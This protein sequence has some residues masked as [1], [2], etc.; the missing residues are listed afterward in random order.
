MTIPIRIQ[1]AKNF[2]WM[3]RCERGFSILANRI[4]LHGPNGRI[5]RADN[6]SGSNT[7]TAEARCNR[8]YAYTHSARGSKGGRRR[9][10]Q[11]RINPPP[12]LSYRPVMTLS[13]RKSGFHSQVDSK[14]GHK[15][16]N[17]GSI[18]TNALFSRWRPASVY[19]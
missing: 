5:K 3:W 19:G 2:D 4:S 7:R 18:H 9:A 1:S 13:E 10:N 16:G 6:G 17:A 11:E 14:S 8:N 12:L 15:P